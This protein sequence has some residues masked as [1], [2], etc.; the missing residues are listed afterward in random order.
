MARLVLFV[1][2]NEIVVHIVSWIV[3]LP[4][5]MSARLQMLYENVFILQKEAGWPYDFCRAANQ[6]T[7]V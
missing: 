5:Q 6:P 2:A 7:F 1:M 4:S 3:G